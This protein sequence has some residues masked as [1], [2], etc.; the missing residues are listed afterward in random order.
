MTRSKSFMFDSNFGAA[1]GLLWEMTRSA[2]FSTLNL[3]ALAAITLS[4]LPIS[5]NFLSSGYSIHWNLVLDLGDDFKITKI[6]TNFTFLKALTNIFCSFEPSNPWKWTAKT[7]NNL[8]AHASW[9]IVIEAAK[10]KV[11]HICVFS[12]RVWRFAWLKGKQ[13][14]GRCVGLRKARIC[15]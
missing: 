4:T 12:V 8:A 15:K 11:F 1:T 2:R 10:E 9:K 13:K 7:N 5:I 6:V 3:W 14:A